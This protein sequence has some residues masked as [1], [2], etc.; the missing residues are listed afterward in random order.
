SSD[1]IGDRLIDGYRRLL[2]GEAT[3]Q[4]LPDRPRFVINATNVQSGAL[5]RFSRPYIWDY[6]VGRVSNPT[7]GLAEA[8]AASSAFPSSSVADPAAVSRTR[9]RAGYRRGSRTAAVHA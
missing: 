2:F 3:L 9:I 4:D 5:F 1:T 8:V 6:R 7:V